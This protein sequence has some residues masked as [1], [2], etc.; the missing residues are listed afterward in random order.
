MKFK[1]IQQVFV[2]SLE[3]EVGRN[4]MNLLAPH[5]EEFGIEYIK[6]S[7]T[8]HENGV[9]GLLESMK[10]LFDICIDRKLD[11]V[12]VLED[13]TRFVVNPVNF[14]DEVLHQMP[15]DYHCLFLACTLLSR[16]ERI[17]PNILRIGSSYCTNAI[18]YSAEAMRMIIP[19]IE[20]NP[21]Q[22]YDVTLMKNLQPDGK[23]YAT[24]PQMCFQRT[25]YS[26][27]EKREMNWELY[28]R[29]AFTM[30]TNGL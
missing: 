7:A 3:N 6:L 5:L 21:T 26:S 13:D 27:I 10:R 20:K 1:D 14:L 28:Q 25:G 29:D 12:L 22:A 30:W 2:V 17:A 8:E 23:C 19:M 15:K 9:I 16:P 18:V 24:L 11:N 4:R